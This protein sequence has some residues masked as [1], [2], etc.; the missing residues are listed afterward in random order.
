MNHEDK[1]L[2]YLYNVS[3][4]FPT[5]GKSLDANLTAQIKEPM[6][7]PIFYYQMYVSQ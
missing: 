3:K 4:E 7:Q 6:A 2:I 1:P 5:T